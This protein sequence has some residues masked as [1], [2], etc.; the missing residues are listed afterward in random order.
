MSTSSA[1]QP[2]TVPLELRGLSPDAAV[3]VYDAHDHEAWSG[4]GETSGKLELPRGLYTIR[5]AVGGQFKETFVRLS[6]ATSLGELMPPRFTAAPLS[7][8][9]TTHEY[10]AYTSQTLSKVA[11]RPSLKPGASQESRLFVFVRALD[12]E[13]Y[14]GTDLSQ[15]LFLLDENG[16]TVS[17]FS[18]AVT[19]RNLAHGWLALSAP[20]PVGF[21]RLLFTGSPPREVAVQLFR[22]WQTQI[23]ILHHERPWLEGMR[24][25]LARHNVGFDMND[26]VAQA[27]DMAFDSLQSGLDRLPRRA[28]DLLLY[29]KFDNPML[30]LVGAHIL[31]QRL[32]RRG[33]DHPDHNRDQNLLETVLGNLEGLVAGS[34]DLQALLVMAANTLGTKVVSRPF[35]RPPMLRAGMEE[36]IQAAAKEPSIV[37]ENGFVD[38]VAEQMY[39]DSPWTSWQ[40]FDTR[41][42]MELLRRALEETPAATAAEGM[43]KGEMAVPLSVGDSLELPEVRRPTSPAPMRVPTAGPAGAYLDWVQLAI[44]DEAERLQG[45]I[46]SGRISS[47][48]RLEVSRL[49]QRLGVTSQAVRRAVRE[50]DELPNDVVQRTISRE[51]KKLFVPRK[52]VGAVK[53]SDYLK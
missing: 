36:I 43:E 52:E 41:R 37:S 53:F 38:R 25:F 11:T 7:G 1:E 28:L 9:A 40:P 26:E 46:L 18:E 27:V 31:L 22:D 50:L 15:K 19:Q 49:A 6:D 3:T 8:T 24:V 51:W 42:K 32:R 44:L 16:N 20:G 13:T 21:Y 10:Y 47:R 39:V 14:K 45:M 48:A 34:P 30:G 33:Q 35:V 5:V 4:R 12:Q 29:S 17:D 2:K 23:F